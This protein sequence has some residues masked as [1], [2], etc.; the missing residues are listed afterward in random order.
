M[1]EE[2]RNV[3][4]SDGLG[5]LQD[6][7][8]DIVQRPIEDGQLCFHLLLPCWE[9]VWIELAT[10]EVSEKELKGWSVR[11]ETYFCWCSTIGIYGK[12]E[13]FFRYL[14]GPEKMTSTLSHFRCFNVSGQLWYFA[15]L[16]ERRRS[17][18]LGTYSSRKTEFALQSGS[19]MVNLLTSSVK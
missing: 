2:H 6:S 14:Q 12:D 1:M 13:K 19:C 9:F 11:K 16:K 8:L 7:F 5:L 18:S 10:F 17:V 15:L 4:R 3:R